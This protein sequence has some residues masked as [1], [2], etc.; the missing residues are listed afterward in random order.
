[1]DDFDL[2]REVS[3]EVVTAQRLAFL[4]DTED[5]FTTLIFRSNVLVAA[6][7]KGVIQQTCGYV[8]IIAWSP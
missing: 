8:D 1:M 2:A 6:D 5:Q 4:P 3:V 7:A